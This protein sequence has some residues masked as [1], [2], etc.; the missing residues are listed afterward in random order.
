MAPSEAPLCGP[1][2]RR[3]NAMATGPPRQQHPGPLSA[4]TAS[5]RPPRA[6]RPPHSSRQASRSCGSQSHVMAPANPPLCRTTSEAAEKVASHV[7]C[8]LV[9]MYTLMMHGGIERK[10]K[11]MR[12]CEHSRDA[13]VGRSKR[14]H[15]SQASG[16][17]QRVQNETPDQYQGCKAPDGGDF[18]AAM[19]PKYD[20]ILPTLAAAVFSKKGGQRQ[21]P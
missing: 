14:G 6:P 12:D 10:R 20:P 2:A 4:P 16:R 9:G 13:G 17:S 3:A 1:A 8:A 19:T 5:A 18:F 11:R 21:G 15:C 7:A